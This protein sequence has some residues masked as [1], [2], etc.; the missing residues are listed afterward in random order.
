[1]WEGEDAPVATG[2]QK[3]KVNNGRDNGRNERESQ[4]DTLLIDDINLTSHSRARRSADRSG[5]EIVRFGHG[6]AVEGSDAEAEKGRLDDPGSDGGDAEMVETVSRVFHHEGR[7]VWD[8][9]MGR[10]QERDLPDAV[11]KAGVV[12]LTIEPEDAVL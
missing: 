4:G 3:K 8:R 6:D 12:Q 5:D 1:M 2:K 11:L 9:R 7:G 10:R